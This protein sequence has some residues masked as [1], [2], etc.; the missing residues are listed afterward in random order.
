MSSEACPVVTGKV[1]EQRPLHPKSDERRQWRTS[2]IFIVALAGFLAGFAG[3]A[4][5]RSLFRSPHE[6][7][8]TSTTTSS[9][10]ADP[11]LLADVTKPEPSEA[12]LLKVFDDVEREQIVRAMAIL[13]RAAKAKDTIRMEIEN[14]TK[15]ESILRQRGGF[16]AAELAVQNR[17]FLASNRWFTIRNRAT[18]NSIGLHCDQ[19]CVARPIKRRD[20]SAS[21]SLWRF[22]LQDDGHYVL[23]SK[24]TRHVLDC[25]EKEHKYLWAVKHPLEKSNVDSAH[26]W[27]VVLREEKFYELVNAAS[28]SS[29]CETRQGE[30][31]SFTSECN[32]QHDEW[33]LRN[34]DFREDEWSAR[35]MEQ[36]S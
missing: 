16:L 27:T 15:M 25:H 18:G 24:D 4:L 8:A 21:G 17:E 10:H 5:W 20:K 22:V 19:T 3:H 32:F 28:G 12:Q 31:F 9:L 23:E 36:L 2:F 29:L 7:S 14:L 1:E 30:Q 11:V 33:E 6:I 35:S 26:S 34:A 13:S